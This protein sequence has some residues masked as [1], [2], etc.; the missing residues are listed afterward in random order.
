[1]TPGCPNGCPGKALG[2]TCEEW[3]KLADITLTG[4]GTIDGDGESWWKG[5]TN[6]TNERP[7]LLDLMWI[8]GLAIENLLIIRPPFWSIHPTFS[9][10]IVV[11][12]VNVSTFGTPNGDGIDIDSSSNVLIENCTFDTGDDCVALKSGMDA[13]G[14]A[15]GIPTSNVTVRLSSFLRGHGCSIGSDMSGG[16]INATFEHLT[17]KGT[18][19][20]VRIKDQRGR[21]G[22]VKGITY[23]NTT[24]EG[25]GQ[26][27]QITQF[28][29][30]GIPPTNSTATP[31]F[32][33][34][35]VQDI[36]ATKSGAGEILCLPE[37]PCHGLKFERVTVENSAG[38]SAGASAAS[39]FVLANAY[40]TST[41]VTPPMSGLLPGTPPKPA[42]AMPSSA[43]LA[44]LA[45]FTGGVGGY[46]TYR[47]PAIAQTR[48][49]GV[50]LA[51][52]EG[53]KLSSSDSDWNDIVMRRS[54]DNG[55][56]WSNISIVHGESTDTHHV[57]I[58]NP[59]PVVDMSTGRVHM[60]FSRN[61]KEI[62][63]WRLACRV[64]RAVV[65]VA[66]CVPWCFVSC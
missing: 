51:F 57:T 30:S 58:G 62:G 65:Q 3:V 39:G 52:C 1:M 4:G 64:L 43:G 22:A 40:G 59:A 66:S 28:Y 25:V 15:V 21:G 10:N 54:T 5:D 13:D 48:Q 31:T 45:V 32:E 27:L 29:H 63:K 2:D 50:V 55:H 53:R 37:R 41:E 6:Q 9:N 20:G 8:D 17:F 19:V 49:E 35:L 33:D 60:I 56:T 14:R 11:R 23:R 12:N 36:R 18:N 44:D 47:I 42:P 16:V 61:N 46:H 7:V 26:V 38:A 24:M 34:F